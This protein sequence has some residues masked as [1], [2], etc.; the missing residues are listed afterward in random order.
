MIYAGSRGGHNFNITGASGLVDEVTED[1]KIYPKVIEY[2]EKAGERAVDC[3]PEVTETKS[4][5]LA[6]G[7]SKANSEGVDIFASIHLNC[8]DGNGHGTEVLYKSE[9]GR[10]YAERIVNKLAALGFTNRGAKEDTR[11]LYEFAHCNMPNVIVEC[12]FCDNQADVDLYNSIGP[13]AIGKA[14]A[15]GILGRD[16]VEEAPSLEGVSKI[17]YQVYVE[18]EWQAIKKD[19]TVAGTTGESKK[20]EALWIN[21][22]G[23]EKITIEGHVQNV[24]WQDIRGNGE[25]IGTKGID[26]RLEALRIKV[27]GKRVAYQVHV[28]GI[29]WMDWCYN[30]DT[31][32]TIGRSLRIEA[33]RILIEE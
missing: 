8:S 5:D 6:Y 1:R 15:E 19:G 26:L 25:I 7:V 32:G 10:I 31:A 29:G 24:G 12:F 21:Y 23:T 13:D 33:I 3:T 14:I 30:W 28:E 16:I 11:G 2:I 27:E 17:E 18:G 22:K 20:I 4:E 9:A